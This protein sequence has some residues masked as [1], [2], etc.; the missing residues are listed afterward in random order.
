MSKAEKPIQDTPPGGGSDCRR[1]WKRAMELHGRYSSDDLRAV[2]DFVRHDFE[3][4]LETLTWLDSLTED[5]RSEQLQ[6]AHE[7]R[8]AAASVSKER[9]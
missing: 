1:S 8:A 2:W 5:A 3:R 6:S 4:F 7:L 9:G